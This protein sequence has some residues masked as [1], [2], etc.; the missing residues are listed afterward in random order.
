MKTLAVAV[1]A[2][3]VVS[4]VLLVG[5]ASPAEQ[6][7]AKLNLDLGNG[8]SM[9]MVLVPPGTFRMGSPVTE[10]DREKDET[11]HEVTISR[12]FYMGAAHVTVD[13]FAS[14]VGDSGYRTDGERA[15]QSVD[16]AIQDGKF[17]FKRDGDGSWRD[18]SYEQAGD[19]PVVHVSW[20][21]AKA[22]CAWLSQKTRRTAVLPTEAQ[23]EYA[24]RA[25]TMTAYP[26]GDS[27][28]DGKGWI[29]GADLSLKRRLTDPPAE[30]EFFTWDDGFVFT[31][32]V[33]SFRANAFGVYD[34][35]GNVWQWVED[36]YGPYDEGPS[37]DPRG[38]PDG[39]RRVL[40]GGSWMFHARYSR[41]AGFRNYQIP[42][43]RDGRTGFRVA[44]L[45]E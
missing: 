27:P 19:H 41:L 9:Q 10:K 33:K 38:V 35:T 5:V 29:N 11:P 37:A 6:P 42:E 17:Q 22:F 7:A 30:M 3:V 20:N 39:S 40:R 26:W 14:F 21:D 2:C 4:G 1:L 32:P 24:A 13:Q 34:M 15:G 25:R 43:Y 28:D 23:W 31:S 12:S 45:V 8:A 16:F 18:T 44:V 36:F